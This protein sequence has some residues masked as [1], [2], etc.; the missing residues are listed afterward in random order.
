[1]IE[2]DAVMGA[3][4]LGELT[5]EE[6]DQIFPKTITWAFVPKKA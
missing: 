1:M 5:E 4:Y 3:L 2:E 6:V